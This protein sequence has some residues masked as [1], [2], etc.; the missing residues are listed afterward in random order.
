MLISFV[1]IFFLFG[2]LAL[3][4]ALS[5]ELFWPGKLF[6]CFSLVICLLLSGA[7]FS[8]TFPLSCDSM[9]IVNKTESYDKDLTKVSAN[10]QGIKVDIYLKDCKYKVGD[11][12]WIKK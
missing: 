11:T 9:L 6:A 7:C 12:L 3:I 1:V 8:S 5:D 10:I 2:I 4:F